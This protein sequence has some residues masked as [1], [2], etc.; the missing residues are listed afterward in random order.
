MFDYVTLSSPGRFAKT[1][2]YTGTIIHCTGNAACQ[3]GDSAEVKRLRLP[4][5][6]L[7]ESSN[8]DR[9]GKNL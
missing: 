7:V 8:S 3:N 1:G 2:Q 5:R 9:E 4:A 6:P